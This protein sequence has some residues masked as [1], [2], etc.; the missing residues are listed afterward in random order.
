MGGGGGICITRA[1]K[2]AF[3][4]DYKAR[5]GFQSFVFMVLFKPLGPNVWP[6]LLADTRG[7]IYV[8]CNYEVTAFV[9]V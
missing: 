1:Y 5:K 8:H 6:F 3:L 2:G 4:L 9:G 7:R